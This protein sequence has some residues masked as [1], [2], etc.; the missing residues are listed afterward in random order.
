MPMNTITRTS[1]RIL[2]WFKSKPGDAMS[3]VRFL[4]YY[5]HWVGAVDRADPRPG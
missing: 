2:G 5:N 4:T 3:M 1:I